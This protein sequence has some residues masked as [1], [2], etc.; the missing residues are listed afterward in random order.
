MKTCTPREAAWSPPWLGSAGH[1]RQVGMS[2]AT[3]YRIK[4]DPA[5]AALGVPLGRGGAHERQRACPL[6]I[7][8][9][10]QDRTDRAR[11]LFGQCFRR[12]ELWQH[13]LGL[14][15]P[16]GRFRS[17]NGDR[18]DALE[19]TGRQGQLERLV[20]PSPGIR[21]SLAGLQIA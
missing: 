21:E 5:K 17:R 7:G 1:R 16:P 4:D 8:I 18:R 2:R 9:H 19:F 6:V 20:K 14:A 15:V 11:S 3:V 10:R 12:F 13:A